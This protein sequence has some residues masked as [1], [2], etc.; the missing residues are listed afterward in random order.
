MK[1][2]TTALALAS[3]LATTAL[4]QKPGETRGEALP[5]REG[6]LERF[7]KDGDGTLDATERAQMQR[8]RGD[9]DHKGGKRRRGHKRRRGIRGGKGSKGKG[10]G[11]GGPAARRRRSGEGGPAEGSGRGGQRGGGECGKGDGA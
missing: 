10:G 5:K 7:D 11:D 3:L 1:R 8:T 9:D 6:I 4:A 2:L